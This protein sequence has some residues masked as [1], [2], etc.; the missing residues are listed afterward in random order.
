MDKQELLEKFL[1]YADDTESLMEW[2]SIGRLAGE[3]RLPNTGKDIVLI[4]GALRELSSDKHIEDHGVSFGLWNQWYHLEVNP[5]QFANK[6]ELL[7]RRVIEKPKLPTKNLKEG[8]F[9]YG[10]K[11]VAEKE[12]AGAVVLNW[13][14]GKLSSS[15]DAGICLI[16]VNKA[17]VHCKQTTPK[18]FNRFLQDHKEDPKLQKPKIMGKK[19]DQ[20]SGRRNPN[21]TYGATSYG[22]VSD[23]KMQDIVF[24]ESCNTFEKQEEPHYADIS[25]KLRKGKIPHPRPTNSSVVLKNHT[26]AQR[27]SG[28]K[29]L[30]KMSKFDHVESKTKW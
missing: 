14:P 30:W 17:A 29:K 7:V 15:K 2:R 13:V 4:Q 25:G 12:G 23:H 5:H 16:K 10:L 18:T 28:E 21:L 9:C 8:N 20:S 11:N 26:L 1:R 22:K 6:N 24:P 3:C 19:Q 27:D